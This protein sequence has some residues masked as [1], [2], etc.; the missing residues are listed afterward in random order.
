MKPIIIKNN[1]IPKLCSWFF[2]VQAITLFPFV[3]AKKDTDEITLR[4]ESIHIAQYSE[5][6]VIGFLFLYMLDY[7]RGLRKYKD[8]IKAYKRIRFEQEAYE[9][10]YC[11]NWVEVRPKKHWKKYKV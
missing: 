5:C 8:K 11:P 7:Y 9:Y 1:L 6:W 10:E 4:H 2:P 3:F